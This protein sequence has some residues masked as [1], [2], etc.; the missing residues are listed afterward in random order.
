LKELDDE[1]N[2]VKIGAVQA[3]AIDINNSLAVSN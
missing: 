3:R 2:L 1:E